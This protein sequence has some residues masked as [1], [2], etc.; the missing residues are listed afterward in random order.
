MNLWSQKDVSSEEHL[1]QSRMLWNL[2]PGASGFSPGAARPAPGSPAAGLGEKS[3]GDRH[4][5]EEM[6]PEMW[7]SR[8][9]LWVAGEGFCLASRAAMN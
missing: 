4:R 3:A 7:E 8:R 6:T 2:P 9:T 1:Y 5:V